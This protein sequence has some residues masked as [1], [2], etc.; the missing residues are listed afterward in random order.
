MAFDSTPNALESVYAQRDKTNSYFEEIHASGSNIIVYHNESG[1]LT[2]DNIGV[3]SAKYNIG[4]SA[5]FDGNRSITRSG[6]TGLNVGGM[7]ITTFLDNFFF[8]FLVASVSINSGVAYLETG[9]AP[10]ITVNGVITPNDETLFGTGSVHKNNVVWNAISS[11]PPYSYSF[12]DNGVKT[13][14]SY[15]TIIQT[16]DNGNIDSGPATVTFLYP[17]LYGVSNTSG[18]TGTA[19]Y[20]ALTLDIT[21]KNNKTYSISGIETYLYMAYPSSYGDLTDASD[22]NLFHVLSAYNKSVVSITSTGLTFNW[23]INYNVYQWSV[24]ADFGGNYQ[25]IF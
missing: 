14:V 19:L 4:Q 20:N 22:P 24:L 21:P 13:N 16:T 7:N 23:T 6:Y 25:F 15:E 1:S 12:I 11:V 9:S 8:P 3:W 10:N 5:S 17:F 2:A 18:L